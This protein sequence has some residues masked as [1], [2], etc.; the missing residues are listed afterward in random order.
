MLACSKLWKECDFVSGQPHIQI[1][2]SGSDLALINR[3]Y[4]ATEPDFVYCLKSNDDTIVAVLYKT[5]AIKLIF[6][7]GSNFQTRVIP[8]S[9][10]LTGA[11]SFFGQ[12]PKPVKVKQFIPIETSTCEIVK[13]KKSFLELLKTLEVTRK[14]NAFTHKIGVINQLKDQ[15]TEE[16][17]FD[18]QVVSPQFKEFLECLGEEIQLEQ[19]KGYLG[20][21]DQKG[22]ESKTS[23]YKQSGEHRTMYHVSPLMRYTKDDPQQVLRKRHIGNDNVVIVFQEDPE[24]V[25]KT[26]TIK[27]NMIYIY[28]V[29][30]FVFFFVGFVFCVFLFGGCLFFWVFLVLVGFCFVLFVVVGGVGCVVVF[31]VFWFF[32]FVFFWFFLFCC[33]W[34]VFVLV[35]LFVG[36][37]VCVCCCFFGFFCLVFLCGFFFFWFCC[38]FV[39]VFLVVFGVCFWFF[40]FVWWFFF[41]VV[42]VVQKLPCETEGVIKHKINIASKSFVALEQL[43]LD[44]EW[45]QGKEMGHQEFKD[46]LFRLTVKCCEICWTSGDLKYKLEKLNQTRVT[47]WLK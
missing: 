32:F 6:T 1:K 9:A 2:L 19:F 44:S 30:C 10:L 37:V 24:C 21:L 8:T 42:F 14:E 7:C 12:K 4:P 22:R 17:I 26:D 28:I 25:F 13:S 41:F 16:E 35:F 11:Q 38:V 34:V 36:G 29:C 46:F 39:C 27:S 20:G 33:G 5:D 45:Q 23:Y 47:D 18:N 31:L 3:V 40:W 15:K 43:T